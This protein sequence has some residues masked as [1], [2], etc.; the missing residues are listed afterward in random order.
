MKLMRLISAVLVVVMLTCACAL[1]DVVTTGNVNM[2]SGPGTNYSVL[3]TIPEGE[4]LVCLG[5]NSNGNGNPTWYNV[6]YNDMDGWI[7]AKYAE[8]IEGRNPSILIPDVEPE[9]P[10]AAAI[11]EVSLF[12]KQDLKTAAENIG[13]TGYQE[14]LSKTPKKYF[15]S[16]LMIAGNDK[17]EL[18]VLFGGKY[19]IFGASVGM[20]SSFAA[21]A[22]MQRGMLFAGS[23]EGSIL[24]CSKGTDAE[25]NPSSTLELQTAEGIVTGIEWKAAGV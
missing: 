23:A 11:R 17:V 20:N 24:F 19:S 9:A 25:G 8:I 3:A 13:L 7:S 14:S 1:A 18:M 4:Q 12:W 16:D 15:D 21:T 5:D 6:R 22:I 2:R 10:A